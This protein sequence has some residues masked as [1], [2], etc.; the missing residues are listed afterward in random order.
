MSHP[1]ARRLGLS[2]LVACIGPAA[3]PAAGQT[4]PSGPS[5][6]VWL[7]RLEPERD[8]PA[9]EV[10]LVLVEVVVRD[11]DGK[12]VTGLTA[13]RFQ[14]SEDGVGRAV[15]SF[16][17]VDLSASGAPSP[18]P[19]V[20]ANAAEASVS[21]RRTF[22]LVFDDG[23]LGPGTAAWA[24]STV[25]RF[26][27]AHAGPG[28]RVILLAP[29]EGL[30]RAA[31]MPDGRA[32]LEALVGRLAARREAAPLVTDHEAFL[33][34]EKD[35]AAAEARVL[36]RLR[37]AGTA[38]PGS[39]REEARRALD[40]ARDRRRRL[41]TS[42]TGV[43]EVLTTERTRKSVLLL[44][45]GFPYEPGDTATYALIA[46]SQRSGAAIDFLDARS[47]APGR[48][49]DAA[50]TA[51]PSPGA[52]LGESTGAELLA[53][54]TGGE[55][56]RGDAEAALA[57]IADAASH[58]YVLGYLP[59][60]ER[61]AGLRRIAVAADRD[62]VSVQARRA[63]WYAP[64]AAGSR[65]DA[66]SWALASPP[67]LRD[68]PLRLTALPLAPAE[69]GGVEVAIVSEVQLGALSLEEEADGSRAGMLDVVLDVRQ[70]QPGASRAPAPEE[71]PIRVPGDA[72]L[73]GTWLPV[74]RRV[75]LTPGLSRIKV[76]VRD[77]RSGAIGSVA[78]LLEVPEPAGLRASSP[79]LSDIPGGDDVE[80]P[81]IVARRAFAP[82]GVL[83]CYFETFPGSGG[84]P[85]QPAPAASS[86]YAVMD[87]RGEAR[88]R[89]AL[90]LP[91]RGKDGRLSRLLE[92]PLARMEPGEYEL[93]LDLGGELPD[94][95]SELRERFSVA[96]PPHFDD[97]LYRGVLAA[98][99]EDDFERAVATLMQWPPGE[100]R[101]AARRIPDAADTQRRAAL[102]LHTELSM[103]LRRHGLG[104][105]AEQHLDIARDLV[106]GDRH[107]DLRREWLLAA[108]YAHQQRELPAQALEL[109]EECARAFPQRG[110]A[111]L[112]AGTLQ[113]RYAFLP[114][115]FGRG[116][117]NLPPLTAARAAERS[118]RQALRVEPELA[119]ARLRLA[120]VLQQTGRVDEA[121]DEL[122]AVL[123]S[124]T[125]A[126]L[127]ALARLFR[128]Q[129]AETRGDERAAAEDYRAA[130]AAEPSLQVAAL[131][132][133]QTLHRRE[134][135]RAAAAVLEP[136]LG[137]EEATSPW[138][139]YRRGPLRLSAPPLD[140]MHARLRATAGGSR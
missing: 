104:K 12:P 79:I 102:L 61:T 38:G 55:M 109:Y 16:R 129:I 83:Y 36:E 106:D 92:I 59:T 62:D 50:E 34:A 2:L 124:A 71:V 75:A 51:P 131:A 31:V 133:A 27:T 73:E 17:A 91:A 60:L 46:A 136:A 80:P 132:L 137:A 5:G 74:R 77:S 30:A 20:S 28:D 13:E 116:N 56:A 119:E 115:G 82:G 118:Y 84:L 95:A 93:V 78:Q 48:S 69:G 32:S 39:P 42:L 134:G 25:T 21:P 63:Y 90:P 22:V 53:R 85:L 44:S 68:V 122:E 7:D 3:G 97:E 89:G 45:E 49:D 81:R 88:L 57:R 67:L 37:R 107:A 66:L 58:H 14:L 33:I 127:V 112:G 52:R 76:V 111:R 10:G 138:L 15:S 6:L 8:A 72:P 65:D 40:R 96:R 54:V 114:D 117:L 64:R 47:V 86:A 19:R 23:H 29:E 9:S 101:S 24:R 130:L 120:R 100:I 135:R 110:E 18:P 123:G 103:L 26:L 41:L 105:R 126:A 99:L 1:L 125:D 98:Y 128:G 43:L 140:E 121:L 70:L 94:G 87:G 113:E 35:D 139:A 108:A 11:P 4:Q